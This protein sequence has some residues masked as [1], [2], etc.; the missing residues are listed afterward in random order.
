MSASR[1]AIPDPTE[2][3]ERY[4]VEKK[5][6]AGR[7]RH[8]LQ[9]PGQEAAPARRDQDDPARGPGRVQRRAR[10]PGRSASSRKP[11]SRPA[12]STRTS[13]RS[14]TSAPGRAMSYIS[15][16][17]VDGVGLDK[18]IQGSGKMAIERAAAIGAQI[19]DA[20]AVAHKH[21]VIHRDIKPANIMIEPGDHV[22]VTDFGIAKVTDSAEHL[23]VTGSLL[24]TPSYMSPE[25]AR[26][27]AIDGR[28]DLFSRRLHPLRDGR[29]PARL[30][31]RVD[32]RAALQ[33]H[34]RGA[35]VA[36]R[37][38]P[39]R[40]RRDAAH[41]RQG[42][43]E[44]PREPLP[45]RPRAGRRPARDHAAGLRADAPLEGH[46]DAPA[47]H[48]ARQHP[49]ARVAAHG[50][51]G[52]HVASQATKVSTRPGPPP[53][54][55]P[56]PPPLAPTV[57]TPA[58]QH[59]APSAAPPPIPKPAPPARPP[60]AAPPRRS[61]GGA[62]LMIGLG[63]GGLL[64]VALVVG[65]GFLL[66][67][68]SPAAATPPEVSPTT[69]AAAPPSTAAAQVA[70]TTPAGGAAPLDRHDA[71][72]S[73]GEHARR[74]PGHAARGRQHGAAREPR[75]FDARPAD[76]VRPCPARARRRRLRAPR[77]VPGRRRRRRPGGWRRA[78]PEIPFGRY[79]LLHDGQV[80]RAPAGA[81]RHHAPGAAGGR[82]AP[83]PQL[84][85]AGLP[86]PQRQATGRCASCT[87]R[88]CSCSTCRS[89]RR[90]SS[91]R[92]TDSA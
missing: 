36:A 72:A 22:K 42:A 92:A 67:R 77:R 17:F 5:L 44:G 27:G 60:V 79:E 40:L 53:I 66:R 55:P 24:G 3:A 38:R 91:A 39:D 11:R 82:D 18:V 86:R 16:E 15:M 50:A 12:C 48:A 68:K 89:T 81:A 43:L 65:G 32:H 45:E 90:A 14:G 75:H 6:G 59:A 46:A 20:L 64:L 41:H 84:R 7:L 2:I 52:A 54:P 26:G 28:S 31:R 56:V 49:D 74:S 10:R 4:V 25:Q 69:L 51:A 35:A 34:H 80:P 73:L 37:A 71:R 29:G 9:G 30:P 58:T 83:L 21:G 19:A 88:G 8:R 63:I 85:R 1:P 61:G 23:T 33:D 13:W 87:T 78:R 62:G 47:R 70:P 57:L 76:R